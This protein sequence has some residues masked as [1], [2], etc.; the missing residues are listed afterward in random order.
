MRAKYWIG[1]IVAAVGWGSGGIATRAAFEEGLDV[2]TMVAGRSTIAA[3]L[4]AIVLVFQRAPLPSAQVLRYGLV[5]AVF[6][7]VV[8]IVLFTFAYAEASAGFVGLLAALIPLATAIFAKFMLPDEPLT[9]AKLVALFIG[10]SGVAA[11]LL[12]GDSGLAEGGRPLLAVG[13]GLTSVASIGYGGTFAKRH[14]GSYSPIMLTGIQFG[15][16]AILLVTLMMTLEG[17]PS[18]V[19]AKGWALIAFMAVAATFIPFLLFFWLMQYI[20]ATEGSLIGYIVPFVALIGGITILGEE[21]QG[22]IIV[23][24]V[25]VF[26]GMVL[27]D[28]AGR[29]ESVRHEVASRGPV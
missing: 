11:L 4:V 12:S 15:L 2:W 28:R 26:T 17:L 10:F 8:P 27:A 14:A 19:T 6:N 18:D 22:G 7:F 24:G 3:V 5:Q 9:A 1:I 13:L 23:G 16:S 20:S 29:K 25:L 21:L